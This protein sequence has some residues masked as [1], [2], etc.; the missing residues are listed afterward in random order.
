MSWIESL[1]GRAENFL[2]L[3]DQAAGQALHDDLPDP[4]A[5]P[6]VWDPHQ[7]NGGDERA[8]PLPRYVA[9]QQMYG[10]YERPRSVPYQPPVYTLAN[11]TSVPSNLNRFSDNS[12]SGY[13]SAFVPHSPPPNPIGHSTTLNESVDPTRSSSRSKSSVFVGK[14]KDAELFEFLNSPDVVSAP[15]KFSPSK[16][17]DDSRAYALMP[18]AQ[19]VGQGSEGRISP[20]GTDVAAVAEERR[21]SPGAVQQWMTPRI[22]RGDVMG[23]AATDAAQHRR[24]GSEAS[25][26]M[27]QMA[28]LEQENGMLKNEVTA[29]H[30]ELNSVISRGNTMQEGEVYSGFTI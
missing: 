3:V 29:L 23:G 28:S 18:S 14:D 22:D 15:A 20:G 10:H 8:F 7:T 5:S 6:L 30:Q 17:P 19:R 26:A 11:S 12:A 13:S 9:P 2:N 21:E 25:A 1:A 27:R 4:S 16:S 24:S